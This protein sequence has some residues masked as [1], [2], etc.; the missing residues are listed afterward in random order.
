MLLR[1][2]KDPVLY[3]NNPKG[4]NRATRRKQLDALAKI[5]QEHYKAYGDDAVLA[6]IRQHEMAFRM[7]T[8]VPELMDISQESEHTYKLYGEDAREPGTFAACCLNARRLPNAESAN[9][10]SRMGCPWS[11]SKEHEDQCRY[12]DR[13]C[14]GLIMDS[15]KRHAR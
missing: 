5:N 10:P 2:E 8:A 14:Y 1:S 7:Q 3:L 15:T 6:R 4:L 12:I 9:G 13:A 11:P